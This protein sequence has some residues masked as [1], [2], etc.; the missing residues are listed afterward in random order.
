MK[1]DLANM[2][3]HARRAIDPKRDVG[4]YAFMLGELEDHVRQV[5]AGTATLDQFADLYMI[6]PEASPTLSQSIGSEQEEGR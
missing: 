1:C 6:R 4:A 5:R 2:L 3:R